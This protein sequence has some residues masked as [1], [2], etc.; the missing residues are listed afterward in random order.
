MA[1]VTL[2]LLAS[3]RTEPLRKGQTQTLLAGDH[4]CRVFDLGAAQAQL[5]GLQVVVCPTSLNSCCKIE[6][7]IYSLQITSEV[8][9]CENAPFE[10]CHEMCRRAKML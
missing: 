9:R 8:V 4:Y 2:L 10:C 6:N 3:G 5:Q 1:R 7:L